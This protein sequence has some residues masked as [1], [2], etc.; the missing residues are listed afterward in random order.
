MRRRSLLLAT[1]SA[2]LG[3]LTG[4]HSGT[5]SSSTTGASTS[6]T[7]PATSAPP[8][9]KIVDGPLP[10][11]PAGT[12]F[13][14]KPALAKG[15]GR[16]SKDLAVRTLI[17]GSGPTAAANDYVQADF[18]G[19]VWDTG[20][21]FDNTYD[22][23]KPI[24]IH[25]AENGGLD[26]WRYALTGKKAGSRIECSV[27]PTW[28]LG[29]HGNSHLGI[30][31]SDTLVFVMDLHA[32]FNAKSSAHGEEVAQ[33]DVSLP[34]AGTNTD[35]KPPAID[36]PRTTTPDK[37]VANYVLKGDGP[38]VK[39]DS[40]VLV[41]YK[42]V[43]WD[44]GKEFDSTYS[45]NTPTAL[46][47]QQGVQGWTQG[48]TGKNVGSRVLLVIPPNLGYGTNPPPG[49]PIKK[50]SALVFTVDILAAT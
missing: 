45:K 13:G 9:P 27:P 12:R 48:L 46:P 43:L 23:K 8:P 18:L 33:N 35:G 47:L 26:G 7:V 19:Q 37:L 40:T 34:K 24:F 15:P 17:V 11:I 6:P 49:S 22:R 44:T 36:I 39:A 16:P 29:T 3:S 1:V 41:Q 21:V 10:A 4:C 14:E 42:G 38:A 28:G 25:L 31:G 30:K 50:N 2:A 32:A 20:K 5:P